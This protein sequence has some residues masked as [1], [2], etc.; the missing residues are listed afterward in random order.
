MGRRV[1]IP[2]LPGL[3]Q[4]LLQAAATCL[5]VGGRLVFP[6]PIT[7]RNSITIPGSLRRTFQQ[8]V[9]LG[10]FLCNLERYEKLHPEQQPPSNPAETGP[11][12]SAS[13][14][15]QSRRVQQKPNKQR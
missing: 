6:N 12:H 10:G 4:S 15:S 14:K 7:R 9:D 5:S 1:P 11:S 13:A 2:D 3:I 8:P